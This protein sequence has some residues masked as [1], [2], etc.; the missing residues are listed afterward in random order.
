MLLFLLFIYFLRKKKC[1]LFL[2][3]STALKIPPDHSG[4]PPALKN[5][6]EKNKQTG[7]R[8][9][10]SPPAVQTGQDSKTVSRCDKFLILQHHL[11][12]IYVTLKLHSSAQAA[13]F[14]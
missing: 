12:L 9:L 5:E 8:S 7:R 1:G 13:N 11:E 2:L 6:V 3:P 4:K 10:S 14:F